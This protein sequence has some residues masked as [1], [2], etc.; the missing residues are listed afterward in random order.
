MDFDPY[1]P[2]VRLDPYAAY[3]RL[4]EDDPVHRSTLGLWFISRYADADFVLRDRRFGRDFDRFLELQMGSG[5]LRDLFTGMMLY[6]DPPDHTRLR[7]LVAKAFT[8]R[9]IASLQPFIQQ[10]VDD[11]LDESMARG[12][13]DVIA[14]L[15]YPLPVMVICQ[16]L[17]IPHGDR[18][19]FRAWSRDLSAALDYMLTP[20]V[21]ARANEA[22]AASTVYMRAL[23]AEHRRQPQQDL[24]TLLIQA[25]E[26]G[27]HLSEMEI[28]STCMFLFG[29]G[30]ETTT[31]LIGN[32]LLA[33]L[34]HP[35]QLDLLTK[36][37]SLIVGAIDEFLRYDSPVQLAG[38]IAI[39]RIQIGERTIEEG[40]VVVALLGAANRDEARFA[41]PD[42]L[43]VARSNAQALS[44]GG[45]LHYCLGA[46]LAKIEAQ[47][48][49]R[50][51]MQRCRDLR[52]TSTPL[53]WRQ[54]VVLRSLESLPVTFRP[55]A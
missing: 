1:D 45:G 41:E 39:E 44:F 22:A 54:T 20:D 53:Q 43:D 38:R 21:V 12:T 46:S 5:P 9:V 40:D 14:D 47:A 17:G 15:A 48:A 2:V 26:Q 19:L 28:V 10:I 33:L 11:L 16:L 7:A 55:R 23:I 27:G 30:H 36:R 4:R 52:L 25:E 29:A 34:H 8:P 3:R 35:S 49:L 32:S 31:G 37:P 24:I 42:R 13:I 51:M 6:H 50:S 18:L